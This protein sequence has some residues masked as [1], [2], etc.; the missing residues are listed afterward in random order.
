[1]LMALKIFATVLLGYLLGS[2]N[3]S[4]LVGRFYGIDIRRHGSGNAGATNTLRTLGKTAALLVAIGD[5]LKGVLAC[6]LG[7]YIIGYVEGIGNL[8]IMLAGL[9]AVIGH[10]WPVYFGFKGGK[11]IFTSITVIFMMDWRMGLLLLGVFIVIVAVTRYVSLGSVAGA[12]LF[13]FLSLL[14]VFEKT[15]TFAFFAFIIAVMAIVRHRENIR[16]IIKG[17]ESKLGKK[18]S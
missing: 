10:N 16:R 2:I 11:G 9:F 13:P 8:G 6:L 7:N 3:T 14:P 18:K 15:L 4:L 17:T 5:V 1:M 12:F